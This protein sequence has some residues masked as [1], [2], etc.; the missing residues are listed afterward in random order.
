MMQDNDIVTS[1]VPGAFEL[2]GDSLEIIGS[3]RR[4]PYLTK[5]HSSYFQVY[6][7]LLEQY[8]QKDVIFVEIGVKDGGSLLMWRDYLGPKARIIGIDI[9]PVAKQ[10]ESQ[11]F[12]IFIGSQSDPKFWELFFGSVGRVDIILDDGGH[13]FEQQI[14]T[15]HSCIP[16][17]REG[18]LVIVE[19]THTSYDREFGY[20]SKYSFIEWT[21]ILID[22]VNSR[23]PG[24]NASNLPYKDTIYSIAIFESIVAFRIQRARCFE[25]APTSN[26]GISLGAE[27]LRYGGSSVGVVRKLLEGVERRIA[28]LERLPIARRLGGW[29]FS[30]YAAL[31][32][33][34]RLKRLRK[35]FG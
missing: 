17:I 14:I 7:D 32:A 22:N 2:S 8:R 11:G 26:H 27:D 1:G 24:V 18:G 4:S 31:V 33:R 5:K 3:Y 9:N 19:D 28:F 34:R 20:P 35:F 15:V 10:L 16:R 30:T 25:S 23:F 6:A 21:K 13:T 12:E 29:I